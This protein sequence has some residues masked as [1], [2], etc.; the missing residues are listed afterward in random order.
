MSEISNSDG[1]R[2]RMTGGHLARGGEER[3]IGKEGERKGSAESPNKSI[4]FQLFL[5]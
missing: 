4:L 2:F 1:C 3:K 5:L